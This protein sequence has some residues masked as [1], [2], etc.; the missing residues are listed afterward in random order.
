MWIHKER[1]WVW[2]L[3]ASL[4]ETHH[5]NC[6][7]ESK[8]E[9]QILRNQFRRFGMILIDWLIASQSRKDMI[10]SLDS[11]VGLCDVLERYLC[12]FISIQIVSKMSR[13][14][15]KKLLTK[16]QEPEMLFQYTLGRTSFLGVWPLM[17]INRGQ[18]E[19]A[20]THKQ[21]TKNN[22]E[23]IL[24]TIVLR[25]ILWSKVVSVLRNS[26]LRSELRS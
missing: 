7:A 14:S 1:I 13:Q 5:E 18:T 17:L 8:F 10:W 6:L 22:I 21:W 15:K 24:Q 25:I 16:N 20:K 11:R 3:F 23:R 12:N 26:L 4:I 2:L 19:E 9:F